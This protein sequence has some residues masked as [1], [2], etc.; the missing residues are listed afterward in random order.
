[1]SLVPPAVE[2]FRAAEPR[3]AREH[4]GKEVLHVREHV[5]DATVESGARALVCLHCGEPYE[6][7]RKTEAQ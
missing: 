6:R 7:V 5:A 2:S 1:M 3:P 4:F